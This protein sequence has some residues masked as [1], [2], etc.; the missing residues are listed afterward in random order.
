MG[1]IIRTQILVCITLLN[2]NPN[3]F[4]S[5]C[6]CH[7]L[8]NAASKAN[9]AFSEIS[10]FDVEDHSGDIYYW[11]DNA[12]IVYLNMFCDQDYER[13]LCLEK[14][15]ARE[16][17]KLKQ[18]VEDG[19]MDDNDCDFLMQLKVFMKLLLSTVKNGYLLIIPSAHKIWC[20]SR[21]DSSFPPNKDGGN[22]LVYGNDMIN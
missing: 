17:K 5:G 14:C 4:V 22:D 7:N 16:L 12:K 1:L 10:K 20:C 21:N 11:F 8:H 15:V 2:K 3:I 18:L 6:P 9:T 19:Y 13:W